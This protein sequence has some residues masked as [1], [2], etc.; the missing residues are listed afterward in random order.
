MAAQHPAD[1][2]GRNLAAKTEQFATDPLVAPPWI[3][4]SEPEDQLLHRIGNWR[5]SSTRS[6]WV[7]PPSAHQAPMP[8]EQRL[9]LDQEH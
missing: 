6:G 2:A 9:G 4:S 8:G 3:L 7:G 1:R 5:S